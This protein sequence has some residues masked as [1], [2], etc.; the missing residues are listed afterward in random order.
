[1]FLRR[2]DMV[3]QIILAFVLV[4]VG[5]SRDPNALLESGKKYL[6]EGKYNE[7]AIELRSAINLNPQLAEAHYN[8]A[9]V[10]LGVG[11]LGDANQALEKTISLQPHNMAAQLKHGNLQ[12]LNRNF[13]EARATA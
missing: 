13:A 9:L 7:A 11:Q 12:L 8:L 1:M 10:Y 6:A 5:C 2:R 4:L 3:G